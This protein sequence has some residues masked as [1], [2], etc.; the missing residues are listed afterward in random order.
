V[1]NV[2]NCKENVTIAAKQDYRNPFNQKRKI[3]LQE[4]EESRPKKY[5][6]RELL[7]ASKLDPFANVKTEIKDLLSESEVHLLHLRVEDKENELANDTEILQSPDTLKTAVRAETST[8]LKPEPQVKIEQ[9]NVHPFD[10]QQGIEISKIAEKSRLFLG[11]ADVA[12]NSE[13]YALIITSIGHF[14]RHICRLLLANV[15]HIVNVASEVP[16]YYEKIS[17]ND[18]EFKFTYRK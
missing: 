9:Q 10:I 15:T 14:Y 17:F 7:P 2:A 3:P 1:P 13:W 4:S 11:N 12:N 18:D 6:K 8:P 16:N 5:T